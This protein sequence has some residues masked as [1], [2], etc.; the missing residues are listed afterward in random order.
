ME[1]IKNRHYRKQNKCLDCGKFVTDVSS[2][3]SPCSKK[4]EN[5]PRWNNTKKPDNLGYIRIY[6]PGTLGKYR[7]EHRLVMEKILGRTLLEGENVHHKNGIKT[8]NSVMVLV[9]Y[10][11][12]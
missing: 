12:S 9:M 10:L 4:W 11:L 1:K 3:C 2:R 8:D 6:I 5:H 7:H